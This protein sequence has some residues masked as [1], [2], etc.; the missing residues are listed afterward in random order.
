MA[1]LPNLRYVECYQQAENLAKNQQLG[2]WGHEYYQAVPATSDNL[3]GGYTR[4]RGRVESVSLTKKAIFVEL[5]GQVSLKIER[6]VAPYID[7]ALLDKLVAMSR[8]TKPDSDLRLEARGWLSD[9]LTWNGKTPELVRQG[10]RKRYQM[11][12]THQ[13]SWQIL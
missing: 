6:K 7:E 12:V 9:R 2:V 5:E 13:V 8:V 11:K 10:R 4:I 1:I 3:K